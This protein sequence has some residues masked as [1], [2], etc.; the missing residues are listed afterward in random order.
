MRVGGI[1]RHF[2]VARDAKSLISVLN[3]WI[4]NNNPNKLRDVLI[5]GEA[6][7]ILFPEKY[8][9]FIL[10]NEIDFIK[11]INK[12]TIAVGAGT[13][14]KKILN[15]CLKNNLAGLEWAAGLPGSLG[16]A[17]R[18]NAGAF[19]GEIKD[20][21]S[22]VIVTDIIDSNKIKIRSLSRKNCNFSYRSS[23][24][25]NKNKDKLKYV[26]LEVHLKLRYKK[27]LEEEKSIYRKIIKYR[28]TKHP[29]EF[30]TLGSIFKNIPLGK[31]S[32]D[33]KKTFADKIKSDPV[34]VLPA[35][36]LLGAAGM[37]GYSVGGAKFSEKHCN[38]IVNYKNAN[39]NNIL[40][41]ISEAKNRVWEKFRVKLKEEIEIIN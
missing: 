2:F 40:Q 27:Y 20:S 13:S 17:V 8:N 37:A 14:V 31:L 11:K 23:I 34:P 32:A 26:I 18:G 33:V 28:K 39:T 29:M 41:L 36:V 1:T 10:K 35:A 7:N 22:K 12:N 6:T 4:K 9:G 15:F 19:G 3:Q 25:K 24:F 5:I 38:F 30:P 16:G 21:V